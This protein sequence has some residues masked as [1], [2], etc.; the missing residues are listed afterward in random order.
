M[1]GGVHVHLRRADDAVQQ[2]PGAD[3][4]RGES[5][6]GV[7]LEHRLALGDRPRRDLVAGGDAVEAGQLL[8]CEHGSLRQVG[9]GA[10]HVVVRMQPDGGRGEILDGRCIHAFCSLI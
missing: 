4:V 8:F 6:H 1:V 7:V 3:V 5:D 9:A 10:Q 2:G